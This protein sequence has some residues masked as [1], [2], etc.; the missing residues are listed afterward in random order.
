MVKTIAVSE[1]RQN[2]PELV[3]R[4]RRLLDRVVITRNG[5]P[6]AV[7]M[8]KGLTV[9]GD[10][11]ELRC[12]ILL[13]QRPEQTFGKGLAAFEQIAEG[14]LLRDRAVVEKEGDRP[15]GWKAAEVR[16]SWIDLPPADISPV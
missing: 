14:N 11:N 2:L 4:M 15:S 5:K 7:M 6:E 12:R 9:A 3:S 16:F 13:I 8:A 10:V 1:A